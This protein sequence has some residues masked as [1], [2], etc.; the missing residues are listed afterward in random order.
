MP[1]DTDAMV[2]YLRRPADCQSHRL[3]RLESPQSQDLNLAR[4]IKDVGG[5]LS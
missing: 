1:G 5:K 4:D 3:D 2:I